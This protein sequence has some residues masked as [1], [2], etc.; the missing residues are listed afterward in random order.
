MHIKTQIIA[1]TNRL[2]VLLPILTRT[3]AVHLACDAHPQCHST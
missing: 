3:G 2:K 1:L